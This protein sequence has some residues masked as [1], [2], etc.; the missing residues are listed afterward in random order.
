MDDSTNPFGM[1]TD[2]GAGLFVLRPDLSRP[3]LSVRLGGKA[4]G[5]TGC[6]KFGRL[7]LHDNI[8]VLGGTTAAGGLRTVNALQ[9]KPGG[10]QDGFVVVLRLWRK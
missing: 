10:E 7:A 6:E 4:A 8:L 1:S 9:T 5:E 2:S 3:E